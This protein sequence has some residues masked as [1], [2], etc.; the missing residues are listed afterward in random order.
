VSI[1]NEQEL[2]ALEAEILSESDGLNEDQSEPRGNGGKI[3]FIGAEKCAG[4]CRALSD[5]IA[6][7]KGD[8]FK[9][10]PEESEQLGA[11]LDPVLAKYM[12]KDG[13]DISAELSLALVALAIV[14]PRMGQAD[15]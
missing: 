6:S 8:K 10:K 7:R 3:E 12:P 2:E 1:E 9:L 15:G 4:I 11:A 14:V 5:L 13:G